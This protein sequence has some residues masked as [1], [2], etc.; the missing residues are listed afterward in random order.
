MTFFQEKF[1]RWGFKILYQAIFD[2]FYRGWTKILAFDVFFFS[3]Y[4]E[5]Q[6]GRGGGGSQEKKIITLV[7]KMKSPCF[8]E[9]IIGVIYV[10]ADA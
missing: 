6:L 8:T 1:L 2:K 10:S 7:V 4:D 9:E 3:R 5:C